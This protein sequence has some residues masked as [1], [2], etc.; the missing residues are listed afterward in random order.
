MWIF[1][2]DGYYSAVQDKD[3]PDQIMVRSRIKKD[4]EAMLAKADLFYPS[5]K[6]EDYEILEWAG[7]DYAY[8]VF[9]PRVVWVAYLAET[10]HELTYTNF[11]GAALGFGDSQRS[12][13]YHN[14]WQLLKDW[15]DRAQR[16]GQLSIG[17]W[18]GWPEEE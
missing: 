18:A 3:N 5:F 1:T 8:R 4:L 10:A 7:T 13:V 12:S 9:I 2:V 6:A 14:I 11:K 15:Q 17:P 16:F